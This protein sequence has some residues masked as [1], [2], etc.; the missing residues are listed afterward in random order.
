[1]TFRLTMMLPVTGLLLSACV[2]T[3]AIPVV[4]QG[5]AILPPAPPPPVTSPEPEL[6]DPAPQPAPTPAPPTGGTITGTV[7]PDASPRAI[8]ALPPGMSPS[9]LIRGA[10]GCYGIA[11]ENNDPPT[12]IPLRDASGAPICDT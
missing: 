1:M 7:P 11:L 4:P 10:D 8:A 3:A 6:P 2:E 12:G 9:F 5:G